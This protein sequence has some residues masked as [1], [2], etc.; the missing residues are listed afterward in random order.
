[1]VNLSALG[2]R[3]VVSVKI[4]FTVLPV[5]ETLMFDVVVARVGIYLPTPSTVLTFSV[6]I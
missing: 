5:A 6:H 2:C 4:Q 3:A 1:M